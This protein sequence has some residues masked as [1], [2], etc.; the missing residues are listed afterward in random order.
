MSEKNMA[1]SIF[2]RVLSTDYMVPNI[3]A[4]TAAYAKQ[5]A[6]ISQIIIPGDI[7][8]NDRVC[9]WEMGGRG[10]NSWG[11]AMLVASPA[12]GII[13]RPLTFHSKAKP[14]GRHAMTHIWAGCI[15]AIGGFSEGTYTV[16][17]FEVRNIIHGAEFDLNPAMC[18]NNAMVVLDCIGAHTSSWARPCTNVEPAYKALVDA[19]IAKL[20][21]KNATSAIYMNPW[22]YCKKSNEA[23]QRQFHTTESLSLDTLD[24]ISID[25]YIDMI[26]QVEACASSL[27]KSAYVPVRQR[28]VSNGDG[29]Y[30]LYMT[31]L[32]PPIQLAN[33]ELVVDDIM[34][35][36]V[37]KTTIT[38]DT[39]L[40]SNYIPLLKSSRYDLFVQNFNQSGQPVVES[41][42][43]Y[44]GC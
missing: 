4:I 37:Y 27:I 13:E 38:K 3:A 34:I 1:R 17:I 32:T 19:T 33:K 2:A 21:T 6:S 39:E 24:V 11:M 8:S 25:K 10:K 23:Y 15:V 28:I 14:N 18:A 36:A 43:M 35:K 26:S 40:P 12:A 20:D 5:P 7:R 42:M 31:V 44:R 16:L 22:T 41:W 30:E 9:L 29:T